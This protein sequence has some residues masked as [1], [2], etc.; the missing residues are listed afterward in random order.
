MSARPFA[1][2]N[3]ASTRR[4]FMKFDIWEF[5]E[6][7]SIENSRFIKIWHEKRAFYVKRNIHFWSYRAHFF[8]ERQM[9]YKKSCIENQ[10]THFRF[11]KHFFVNRTAFETT[12]KN[13]V[14]PGRPQM[15]IRRMRISCWVPKSYKHT[16]S[17]YV[18]LIVFLLQV[19]AWTRLMLYVLCL[20]C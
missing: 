19:S 16:L 2:N 18:I 12:W 3:S 5:F 9:F 1:W 7:L 4:I 11:N 14:E 13:T 20:P 8:L 15:K 17:E 10:N 6:N